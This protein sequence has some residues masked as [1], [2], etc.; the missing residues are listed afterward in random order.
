[1]L[2]C[3]RPPPC[4]DPTW[5]NS[6][7]RTNKGEKRKRITIR[8]QTIPSPPLVVAISASWEVIINLLQPW[9]LR[10]L[11]PPTPFYSRFPT[12]YESETTT[13]YSVYS[14]SD[15]PVTLGAR[16]CRSHGFDPQQ[17]PWYHFGI[18]VHFYTRSARALPPGLWMLLSCLSRQ[19]HEYPSTLPSSY[20]AFWPIT[21]LQLQCVLG[22][23]P[24][25]IPVCKT[26]HVGPV[27]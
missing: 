3:L 9:T 14:S 21:S 19:G 11:N 18:S 13:F 17:T 22:S 27:P 16:F 25:C 20:L 2:S 6:S 24:K 23:V 12:P 5:T 10:E 15:I 7:E 8:V 4:F 26:L 1:M